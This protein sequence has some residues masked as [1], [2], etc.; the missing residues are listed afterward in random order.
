MDILPF[1]GEVIRTIIPDAP[2]RHKVAFAMSKGGLLDIPKAMDSITVGLGWDTDKGKIDLDVSAVLLTASGQMV[3]TVYFGKLESVRHGIKHSG[4]NLT[5]EGEG[6]DEQVE[7]V[8]GRIGQDVQQ[9]VFVVNVYTPTKSFEDVASPYCRVIDNAS[10]CE[11]YRYELRQA[12]TDN[13]LVVARIA[14]EAADQRR[15]SFHALGLP[16]RGRTYLDSLPQIQQLC[17][18]STQSLV[19]RS[20]SDEGLMRR[21]A[22]PSTPVR[23]PPPTSP[24]TSPSRPAPVLSAPGAPVVPPASPTYV[25]T[26]SRGYDAAASRPSAYLYSAAAAGSPVRPLLVRQ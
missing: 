7:A 21:E 26:P 2:R 17:T 14:R 13:G 6:D 5:G 15:W 1:L 3:E 20:D 16:C 11:M 19:E 18:V 24:Y 10:G 22:A 8:L 9:V 25:T 4:D 12:G 23:P